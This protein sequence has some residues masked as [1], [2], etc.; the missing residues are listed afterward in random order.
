MPDRSRRLPPWHLLPPPDPLLRVCVV[1]P[2]RD[3]ARR[4]PAALRAL[5]GQCERD[6]SPFDC[7]RFEVIVLANNCSDASA[8]IV[9]RFAAGHP[10]LALHAV[11]VRFPS[12]V[13]HVGHAR[14]SL[15][16]EASRRLQAVG[17]GVI[18][19][20]DGDTCVAAD[21]LAETLGAIDAGADAVGGRI[22]LGHDVEV[23]PALARIARRDETYQRLRTQLEHWLDPDDADPLPRHHQHFGAS[24]ALTSAAYI[25]VGGVPPIRFLEDEALYQALRRHDFRVRHSERVSVVTSARR[26]GRVEVGYS[27]QLR[28]WGEQAAS[29]ADAQVDDPLPWVAAMALRRRLR[30]AWAAHRAAAATSGVDGE[31][32][33]LAS[34][35]RLRSLAVS[36]ALPPA[37]LARESARASSFGR[38]WQAVEQRV[39]DRHSPVAVPMRA[40][41]ATLRALIARHRTVSGVSRTGRVGSVPRAAR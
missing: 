1:V 25:A 32:R 34:L 36:H 22:R 41:I 29:H 39:R 28:V 17:G 23:S 12:A 27:W 30:K 38:L 8:D 33:A 20:T 3:E 6:G 2:V 40:A 13:A 19:S 5:A 11:E 24:L 7:R 21:W 4:L 31:A 9:R 15:M 37:W 18:A 26:H 16:Q 14:A 35:A 10:D